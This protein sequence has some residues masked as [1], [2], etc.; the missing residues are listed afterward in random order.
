MGLF[1]EAVTEGPPVVARGLKCALG[2]WLDTLDDETRAEAEAILADERWQH[3]DIYELF[4][5]AGLDS[6]RITVSRHRRGI[7]RNCG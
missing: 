2:T 6:T 4:S 1:A 3:S 5:Q 7:C